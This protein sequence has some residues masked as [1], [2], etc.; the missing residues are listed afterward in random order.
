MRVIVVDDAVLLREGLT[1]LLTEHGI[2][3]VAQLPDATTLADCVA[4]HDPDLVVLDIR[5]PPTNTTEG[6]DAALKL[7]AERPDVAVLLLSQYIETQ[8][9]LSLIEDGA[10]SV[11]Y[12]LKDRIVDV[13][14]FIGTLRRVA[15]GETAIDPHVVT[16]L[17]QRQRRSDPLEALTARELDV[18]GLMAEGQS[19]ETI[20]ASLTLNVRTVE[21]HIG[22]VFTKLDLLPEADTH[23]R[24]RAVLLYLRAAPS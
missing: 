6:L 16:R 7:R 1:R 8:D 10:A 22:N 18:L 20:A 19:N 23:R 2:D 14:Q 21:T 4:E 13:D 15:A 11:G 5:M 12:L 9:A 17:V 3:V 24:V